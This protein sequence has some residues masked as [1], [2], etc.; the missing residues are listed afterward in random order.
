MQKSAHEYV[1]YDSAVE[2]GFAQELELN[3][4][5]KIYAKLPGWFTVPTPLGSYNPDWA[6]LV[7][8]DGQERLY[9]VV[10]TKSP[11]AALLQEDALRGTE[12]AKILCGKAHFAALA[13]GREKQNPAKYIVTSSVEDMLD[14]GMQSAAEQEPPIRT[15]VVATGRKYSFPEKGREELA[16]SAYAGLMRDF[17]NQ[18]I[19]AI[20]YATCLLTNPE[21]CKALLPEWKR[22][23]FT[24]VLNE[25]GLPQNFPAGQK[26]RFWS[27]ERRL[28]SRGITIYP[29][30]WRFNIPDDFDFRNAPD[31]TQLGPYLFEA[32]ERLEQQSADPQVLNAV[33]QTISQ[34]METS[35][36]AA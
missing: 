33:Q 25:S 23:G 26:I 22:Q 24:Q 2:Q 3:E 13:E 31:M 15:P 1:V 18:T 35:K 19:P 11:Q 36:Q 5:I 12:Y 32:V 6:V 21:N 17:P 30:T 10:E 4:V 9:F 34:Q 8:E 28:H 7:E 16:Y 20:R 14:N 27:I 29:T